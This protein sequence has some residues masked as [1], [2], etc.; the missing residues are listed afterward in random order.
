MAHQM[1]DLVNCDLSIAMT[2]QV[3]SVLGEHVHKPGLQEDLTFAYWRLSVGSSRFTA[4]ITALILPK[5]E[6]RVLHGNASFASS[7]L[8]RVLAAV[9]Q[10]SGVAFIH[11]HHGP[12]WQAMSCDDIVAERDRIAGPVAGKT[13]LPLVGLTRGVD[14]AWSG[15]IWLRDAPR[16]YEQRPA[17]TVRVVGSQ[18]SITYHPTAP[19]VIPTHSQEA[20]LSVWGKDAQEKLVRSRVGIVGLGSVGS[21][22]S[23]ALSRLGLVDL[24]YIDFDKIEERNLDRTSGATVADI[25][26]LKV[27]VAADAAAHSSTASK[28]NLLSIPKSILVPEGLAAA[29]DCDVLICCV[30]RPWPRHLLNVL[31]YSHLIPVID[32]GIFSAVKP[33]GAPL[34]VAWSIHTIGPDHACL[35]CLNA[36]LRSDVGLDR[37]GLLDDPDYIEGLSEEEKA[38]YTRR[39]VF[40]FSMSVAAHEVLQLVGLLTGFPRIGGAGPQRYDCYPGTMKVDRSA[41]CNEVCE[42]AELTATAIDLTP[43]LD[44]RHCQR[45]P[46]FDP[47]PGPWLGFL[48]RKAS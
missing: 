35:V 3:D 14:G 32:G 21:L 29:L 41:E 25:G 6:E 42:F 2:S 33:D 24:T 36:L 12:G 16:E 5:D 9:P 4:V 23:E 10:G 45:R 1:T 8:R 43:N 28:L 48:G 46:I 39:N 40:P 19:A 18:L 20:T 30:D 34:H 44:T 38:K 7:Y 11:G 37:D 27:Y 31:A 13:G 17:G 15:R 47:P 22:V 26:R